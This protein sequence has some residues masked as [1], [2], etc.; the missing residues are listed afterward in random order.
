MT[1]QAKFDQ[2]VTDLVDVL[3]DVTGEIREADD[4]EAIQTLLEM[5]DKLTTNLKRMGETNL[6]P[7]I[8]DTTPL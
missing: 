1:N 5:V 2:S 8:L 6:T 4:Y 7:P 3:H